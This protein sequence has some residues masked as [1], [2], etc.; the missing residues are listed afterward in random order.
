M[1]FCVNGSYANDYIC[2]NL[3]MNAQYKNFK[4]NDIGQR[5]ILAILSDLVVFYTISVVGI[6]YL[7]WEVNNA[8]LIARQNIVLSTVLFSTIYSSNSAVNK[9]PEQVFTSFDLLYSLMRIFQC[10]WIKNIA[11]FAA[12]VSHAC[13]D[14]N[15]KNL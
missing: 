7:S 9:F 13:F 10:H 3:L 12:T 4:E 8:Y 15:Y 1:H 14:T 5:Q 2:E 11:V 6:P